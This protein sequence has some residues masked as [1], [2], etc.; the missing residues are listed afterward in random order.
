MRWRWG[1]GPVFVYE[2]V[3]ASRRW[4]TYAVRTLAAALP[5]VALALVWWAKLGDRPLTISRLAAVGE[6][7]FIALVSIQLTLVLLAAPAY[8]AGAICRDKM[9]G[10]LLHLLV[11]D[12]SNA[13]V[14]LGKLAARLLP[15]LGLIL[16]ATPVLFGAVLLGGIP[17]GAALGAFAILLGTAVLGSA[18]ALTLSVWLRKTHEVLLLV[19]LPLIALLLVIPT[20]NALPSSWTQ[21]PPPEWAL[22]INPYWMAFLPYLRPGASWLDAQA[23]YLGTALVLSAALIGAAVW[24]VRAVAVRQRGRQQRKKPRGLRLWPWLL[25]RLPGPSL[26]GNPVLWREWHRRR[27]SFWSGLA[28]TLYGGLAF[29]FTLLAL[30]EWLISPR[31]HR[32]IL[33]MVNGFQVSIGLLLLSITSVTSLAEERDRGSLDVL[34][35]TPLSALQILQGKWWGAYRTV[36]LLVLMPGLI[37]FSLA[38]PSTHFAAQVRVLVLGGLILAVMAS[39]GLALSALMARRGRALAVA[40]ALFVLI[41][42]GIVFGAATFSA[43]HSRSMI[44]ALMLVALILV[45]GAAVTSLGLALATW[46]AR[47]GR[48]LALAVTVFLLLTVVPGLLR[49]FLGYSDV[50]H[51]LTSAS[52]FFGMAE[53]TWEIKRPTWRMSSEYGII[54]D[55]YGQSWWLGAYLAA[56][57]LLFSLTWA[58]FNRCLGRTDKR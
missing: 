40:A 41:Y 48:A 4:Q 53:L 21:G 5:G 49:Q 55:L 23:A 36:F 26:N 34:L 15:V 45:Y 10:T 22:L 1:P 14:V 58:S 43:D 39:F 16:A 44:C 17:P 11:T 3:I 2:C 46:V 24:R 47:T 33:E 32:G 25:W 57:V 8:T 6:S 9:R 31:L 29:L 13:E 56:A 30:G 51:G 27:L 7:F 38:N 28:W 35:T 19:Y 42:L 20:W 50:V 54:F 37:A 52:P 18:L 12:L